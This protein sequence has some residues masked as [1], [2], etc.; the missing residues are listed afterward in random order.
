MPIQTACPGC[1][2]PC[3]V[4]DA[5]RGK[6]V[7]C[8]KCQQVF[9]TDPPDPEPIEVEPVPPEEVRPAGRPPPLPAY[10]ELIPSLGPPR[11]GPGIVKPKQAPTIFKWEIILVVVVV[12]VLPCLGIASR[13]IYALLAARQR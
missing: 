3:L 4:P 5:L 11:A 7:R 2:T 12:V 6:K 8:K 1:G 13:L 9:L 10:Q